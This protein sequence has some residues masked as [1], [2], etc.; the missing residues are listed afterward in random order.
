MKQTLYLPENYRL[1][2]TR[3]YIHSLGVSG[4][5][6]G[7]GNSVVNESDELLWGHSLEKER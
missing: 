4:I 3:G 1:I 2:K 5:I 7:V 6:V